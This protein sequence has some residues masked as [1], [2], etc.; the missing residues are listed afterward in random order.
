MSSRYLAE[1]LRMSLQ[2]AIVRDF[3]FFG[4]Q[5]QNPT[6]TIRSLHP[7]R[8]SPFNIWIMYMVRYVCTR[9]CVTAY[10]D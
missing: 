4:Q 7:S 3:S 8:E 10:I 2:A 5:N 6:R 9:L 1:S